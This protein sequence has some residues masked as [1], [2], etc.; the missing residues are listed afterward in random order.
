V[1][2]H[3]ST[4]PE[5]F[6]LVIA[7]AM[8]CGRAV[9]SSAAGGAAE[10]I[11]PGVDALAHTPGDADEL[12]RCIVRLTSDASLRAALGRA[13]HATARARF[14][15]SRLAAEWVPI[16]RGLKTADGA[17]AGPRHSSAGESPSF[18]STHAEAGGPRPVID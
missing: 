7:E 18:V 11:T 15:R 6:G 17:L 1:V 8:A 10:I 14:D 3:A 16:Y 2:V 9:V 13:A 5:P 12:A 4:G